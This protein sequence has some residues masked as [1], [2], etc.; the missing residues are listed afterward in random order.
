MWFRPKKVGFSLAENLFFFW[1]SPK[2]GQKN[3]LNLSKDLL[4]FG[5]HQYLDTKTDSVWLKTDQNLGQDCLMLF[6]ASKTAP[7]CKFL[8]T[9][10]VDL[11]TL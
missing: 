5:D 3:R 2:F 4:F 9:L 8:A 11:Q 6:P 10:L 1:W 7:H